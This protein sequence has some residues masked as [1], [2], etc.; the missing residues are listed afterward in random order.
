MLFG[1]PIPIP[2]LSEI[3]NSAWAWAVG[4]QIFEDRLTTHKFSQL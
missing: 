3:P 2:I 1:I 4:F